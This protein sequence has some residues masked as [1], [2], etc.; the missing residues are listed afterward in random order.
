VQQALQKVMPSG[1]KAPAGSPDSGAADAAVAADG[2]AAELR[3]LVSQL[4]RSL[5]EQSSGSH[6]QAEELSQLRAEVLELRSVATALAT[7]VEEAEKKEEQRLDRQER[8]AD[9]LGGKLRQ[10][11]ELER[12]RTKDLEEEIRRSVEKRLDERAPPDLQST[13]EALTAEMGRIAGSLE[14]LKSQVGNGDAAR[15]ALAAESARRLSS[16]SKRLEA[17][18]STSASNRA[19]GGR[20]ADESEGAGRGL[21]LR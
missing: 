11:A 19:G 16:M 4:S 7:Q 13:L 1:W 5:A 9:M 2:D 3:R 18:E 15:R 8:V 10:T 14:E 17:L 21:L 12:Q 6:A 20:T